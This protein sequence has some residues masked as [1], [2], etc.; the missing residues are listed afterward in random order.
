MKTV[1]Y[2]AMSVNG[3][4]A[5]NDDETPWSAETWESYYKIA[6]SCKVMI[7]GRR[8][9]EI[10]VGADEFKKIGN[11][12][13]IVI[14][15]NSIRRRENF[16]FVK[17]ITAAM[18]A[19]KRAKAKKVLI[20]G[21]CMT[22]SEFLNRK[23][24]DEIQLDIEPLVIGNGIKLFDGDFESKLKLVKATKISK[25]VVHLKYRVIK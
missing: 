16:T 22:N 5:R 7:V 24:I 14:S 1:M 17:N 12:H 15:K 3:M 20:G 4:I 10:M 19:A 2:M 8:T 9:Y 23:L 21:G 13:T 25:H 18:N 6:K 11:P